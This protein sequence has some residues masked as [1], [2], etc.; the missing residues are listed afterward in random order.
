MRSLKCTEV[1]NINLTFIVHHITSLHEAKSEKDI[2]YIDSYKNTMVLCPYHHK[3]VHIHNGGFSKLY[4]DEND[5]LY[6]ENEQKE[7]IEIYINYHLD[8]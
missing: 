5:I 4:K 3:Y 1:R 2:E 8:Y 7:K 6:L